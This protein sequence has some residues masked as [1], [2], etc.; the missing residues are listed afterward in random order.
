[1]VLT[2]FVILTAVM[3]FLLETG[4]VGIQVVHLG[5]HCRKSL[6]ML[7]DGHL[8]KLQSLLLEA[9]HVLFL[10]LQLQT[11]SEV[12]STGHQHIPVPA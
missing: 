12:C 8:V 5:G 3:K 7:F 4:D 11:P 2:T 1:M 9:L 10:L 6:L